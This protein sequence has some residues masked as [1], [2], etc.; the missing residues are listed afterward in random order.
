MSVWCFLL[1]FTL[2][3]WLV[4]KLVTFIVCGCLDTFL[5]VSSLFNL[6]THFSVGLCSLNWRYYQD[7][8]VC[9]LRAK[10]LRKAARMGT[11][12]GSPRCPGPGTWVPPTVPTPERLPG[13]SPGGRCE[14]ARASTLTFAR[15]SRTL[16]F[17]EAA[18]IWV[19]SSVPRSFTAGW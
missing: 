12:N 9:E 18:F 2:H 5:F 1:C 13:H 6:L 3:F 7:A 10:Q 15:P 14:A 19:E 16:P 17:G 11:G 8:W 4:I